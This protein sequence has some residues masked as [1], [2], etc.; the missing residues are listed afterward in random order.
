[1]TWVWHRYYKEKVIYEDISPCPIF[2]KAY[3]SYRM[4]FIFFEKVKL[5]KVS[6]KGLQEYIELCGGMN[7]WTEIRVS[8]HTFY[9][10]EYFLKWIYL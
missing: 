5:L 7:I 1:M 3:K 2:Q 9:S 4:I 8:F 6:C 10:C